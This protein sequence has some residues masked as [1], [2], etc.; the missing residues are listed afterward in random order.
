MPQEV[1]AFLEKCLLKIEAVQL[2]LR[3]FGLCGSLSTKGAKYSVWR[4]REKCPSYPAIPS[5]KRIRITGIWTL[6]VE[7]A[8][9]KKVMLVPLIR[10]LASVHCEE[11]RAW[12]NWID[13]CWTSIIPLVMGAAQGQLRT[14]ERA[15]ESQMGIIHSETTPF[16]AAQFTAEANQSAGAASA[17]LTEE[18]KV[19]QPSKA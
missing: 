9:V 14:N 16:G 3:R 12:C 5:Q 2:L 15:V 19:G 6:V 13:P 11:G 17:N 1:R 7:L 18:D 4:N 10:A 8:G